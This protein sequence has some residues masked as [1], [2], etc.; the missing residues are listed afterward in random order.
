MTLEEAGVPSIAVITEPFG[1]KSRAEVKALGLGRLAIQILPH[2]IG[3]IPDE[4]MR[5]L[6]DQ[7]FDEIVFALTSNAEQV[8]NR[9]DG[10]VEPVAQY[11]V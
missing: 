1:F 10:A 5:A 6:A 7:A 9:Y 4:E 11:R 3:Q 8:A 2:P